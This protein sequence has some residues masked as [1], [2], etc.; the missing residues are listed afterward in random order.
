ML[1]LFEVGMKAKIPVT[2]LSMILVLSLATWW[3]FYAVSM[4][5]DSG[6]TAVVVGLWIGIVMTGRW[7]WHHARRLR[8]KGRLE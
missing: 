5:L 3:F 2:L 8:K 6:A 7:I 1:V 4:R